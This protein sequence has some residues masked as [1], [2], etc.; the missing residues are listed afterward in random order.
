MENHNEEEMQMK[1]KKR[2]F[3]FIVN[4]CAYPIN[5]VDVK[6][7]DKML[8]EL[9]EKGIEDFTG[10]PFMFDEKGRYYPPKLPDDCLI[11][12]EI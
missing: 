4:N 1:I 5:L 9:K 2:F 6:T 7:I 12:E 10:H 8:D 11:T 3:F